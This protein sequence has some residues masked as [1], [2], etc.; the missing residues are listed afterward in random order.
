VTI[1]LPIGAT[2]LERTETSASVIMDHR[3]PLLHSA[4]LLALAGATVPS[5]LDGGIAPTPPANS[6]V[7]AR[8]VL[9]MPGAGTSAT[10]TI[11][12]AVTARRAVAPTQVG[13]HEPT[14][15]DTFSRFGDCTSAPSKSAQ[16]QPLKD[17]AR[18]A[19]DRVKVL[20]NVQHREMGP[21]RGGRD[22]QIRN[23]WAPMFDLDRPA[24]PEP[25]R[26]DL[27][28]SASGTQQALTAAEG[29]ANAPRSSLAERAENP[30]S[31]RVT[32]LILTNPR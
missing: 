27:R 25:R 26:P 14:A 6:S 12:G 13:R 2:S 8:P 3:V 20:V 31:S 21:F 11:R 29:R 9:V 28:W 18:D 17:L 24:Q 23:R 1:S 30:T 7:L 15:R 19:G 10:A 5:W 4:A 32:V 16:G 22:E